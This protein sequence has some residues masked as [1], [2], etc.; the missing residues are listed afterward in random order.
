MQS[1]TIADLREDYHL[2]ELLEENAPANPLTLFDVWLQAALE[3]LGP[4][5]T[6]MTLATANSAGQPSARTVLLK[7]VEHGT[8]VFFG[9]YASRKGQELQ[10]NDRAALLFF[11]PNLQRQVRID[12][13]V[14][15]VPTAQSDTYFASRPHQ[16]QLAA[17]ASPQSQRLADR[18][19]LETR[20]ADVQQQF[21]DGP[22]PRPPHWG[23]WGLTPECIEFW[24][25]RASRLHDRL[26]YTAG[27]QGWERQRLAP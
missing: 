11:W 13:Q 1:Q 12:G 15:R 25:G 22:V 8:L 10:A 24:Q 5:A 14:R 3:T 6:A 23:G 20:L 7:G 19:E 16:S 9:N 27:V 4:T 26:V 2:S 21:G 17:W 18:A